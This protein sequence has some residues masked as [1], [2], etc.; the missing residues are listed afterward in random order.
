MSERGKGF[1]RLSLSSA[2]QIIEAASKFGRSWKKEQFAGFGAKNN[3]GS[4]TSGAFAARISSLRDYGLVVSD[5][6]SVNL[7][8]LGLTIS[9]PITVVEREESIRKAFLSVGTFADLYASFDDSIALPIDKIAEHAVY[10]LGVSRDSK[11]KFV[12]NFIDSGEFVKLVKYNK[13]E[14][15]INLIKVDGLVGTQDTEPVAEEVVENGELSDQSSELSVIQEPFKLKTDPNRAMTEQGVNHA[16]DGWTLTV[17][18]KSTNRLTGDART[19]VRE[20]LA[21]ADDVA[22]ELHSLEEG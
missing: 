7:T 4:V 8:E 5:K 11:D 6:E 22:D 14:K 21:L 19:K 1:P 10:N 17:L 12:K 18:L 16:G 15:T 2:V 20:M 13:E 9:K 3:A